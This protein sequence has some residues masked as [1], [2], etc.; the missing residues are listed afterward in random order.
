MYIFADFSRRLI[1]PIRKTQGRKVTKNDIKEKILGGVF[2]T[3]KC[4]YR[5]AAVHMLEFPNN[6]PVK[7]LTIICA[8]PRITTL[9]KPE[10]E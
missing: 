10:S 5:E 7:L 3:R 9:G 4:A 2:I 1:Q 6:M 8:Y